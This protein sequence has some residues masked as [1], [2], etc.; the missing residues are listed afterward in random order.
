[1][2]S[3]YKNRSITIGIF[4]LLLGSCASNPIVQDELETFALATHEHDIAYDVDEC[5]AYLSEE[6][7]IEITELDSSNINLL[8][9]NIK[10]GQI[11]QWK[12]DLLHFADGKNLV[13]IQE[14]VLG[15]ELTKSFSKTW[16]WSFGKGYQTPKHV[17][18]VMTFSNS[19]PLTHCNFK[20]MEPWLGTAKAT[21]VTEYGLLGTDDTLAVVNIHAINFSFGV[22]EFK[23]QID[24]VREVLA[25][26]DGPV[27]LSGD[28]NTWR[29][30][31]LD[32]VESLAFDLDLEAMSFQEDH[33]KTAFG[34]YLDHLYVRGLK[35]KKTETHHIKT[36]DHNPIIAEFSI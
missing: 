20:N 11:N 24:Q 35:V 18:G 23:Q 14:A 8:S 19:E 30:R 5:R 4:T 2:I 25:V 36:S 22:K 16:S 26:H 32:I 17:T 12:N 33:R 31:R 27:I 13:L 6:A 7:K 1:M 9:W 3:M 29:K 34:F 10:K 21:T 28:F 15:P